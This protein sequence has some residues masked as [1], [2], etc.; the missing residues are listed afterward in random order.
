[1]ESSGDAPVQ[2]YYAE[3]QVPDR[4]SRNPL[5]LIFVIIVVFIVV[6]ASFWFIFINKQKKDIVYD[7]YVEYLEDW[8][9]NNNL[10]RA[11]PGDIVKVYD[12]ISYI[13]YDGDMTW[14]QFES[15]NTQE[16]KEKGY[17]YRFIGFGGN[18]MSRYSISYG[19]EIIVVF[20]IEESYFGGED[21]DLLRIEH[22]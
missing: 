22:Q 11:S 17:E 3:T 15:F 20:K 10:G 7:S 19:S 1:M 6:F 16:G 2:T 13:S 12:T 4:R 21:F 14:F 9:E 5:I 18:L 8:D